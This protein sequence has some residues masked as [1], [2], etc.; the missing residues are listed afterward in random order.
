MNT[1]HDMAIWALTPGG[2]AIAGTLSR[3]MGHCSLFLS[4]TIEDGSGIQFAKLPDAVSD[5]FHRFR[6]HVFIMS[7]GIVVRVIAPHIRHKTEDP[8]V[9]VVDD[10]GRF[11]ISLLS[12]HLG[13]ANE[14]AQTVARLIGGIPVITTAT[15]VNG[16]P[17]IDMIAK[18]QNLVIE[19]PEAIKMVNMAFIK[20]QKIWI[21]DKYGFL[22]GLI[23]DFFINDSEGNDPAAAVVVDD[24]ISQHN[25]NTL[26]LRPR[27]LS[28]GI[29]CNRGTPFEEIKEFFHDVCGEHGISVH[30]IRHL[31]TIDLKKDERGILDLAHKL[32]V[33]V[34]FYSNR[35]LDRVETIENPSDY[36]KK[37]TGARSVCEAAAILASN[38]GKLIVPKKKTPNVTIA[39]AREKRYCMS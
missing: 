30:S 13:G 36:A 21:R 25:E 37:H 27:I 33:P 23:P 15:D 12:G 10:S 28:A 16:L 22:H 26:F 11:A 14:L 6:S 3:H 8:A 7:A 31:A 5:H 18:R 35:T 4:Q 29:G 2:L 34:K 24:R 1:E 39:L 19:N 20:N 38:S 9:V 32:G 17:S